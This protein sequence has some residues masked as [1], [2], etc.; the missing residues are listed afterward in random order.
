M[1][2]KILYTLF[3]CLCLS[4]NKSDVCLL[5]I[6]QTWWGSG[7]LLLLVQAD[8]K[9]LTMP[10]LPLYFLFSSCFLFGSVWSFQHRPVF[11]SD[12]EDPDGV[13]SA[14]VEAQTVV[15]TCH[16]DSVEVEVVVRAH[17]LDPGLV[18]LRLGPDGV[19]GGPCIA[20]QSADGHLSIRAPLMGCGSRV[21]V[22]ELLS[23]ATCWFSPH[24]AAVF[25]FTDGDLLYFNRLLLLLSAPSGRGSRVE[26]AAVPV[27]CK[28]R[29]CSIKHTAE[30]TAWLTVYVW[31]CHGFSWFMNFILHLP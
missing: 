12:S 28:H 24:T 13:P 26:A 11:E 20:W 25:Q 16:Q 19:G 8:R 30:H 22:G 21:M 5:L 29:R 15:V 31:I 4:R 6:N 9:A 7:V 27:L 3:V 14:A 10:P 18:G 1:M 23:A 2:N 17:L